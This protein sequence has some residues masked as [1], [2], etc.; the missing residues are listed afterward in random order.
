MPFLFQIVRY[1]Q[2]SHYS[3]DLTHI[4]SA[5][6]YCSP[7]NHGIITVTRCNTRHKSKK[8]IPREECNGKLNA[9]DYRL[10]QLST[11]ELDFCRLSLCRAFFLSL[12]HTARPGL[13]WLGLVWFGSIACSCSSLDSI[14]SDRIGLVWCDCC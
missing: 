3:T 8:I 10:S 14:G 9:M 5:A 1:I 13:D 6:I 4:S 7:L 12:S 11:L 2:G